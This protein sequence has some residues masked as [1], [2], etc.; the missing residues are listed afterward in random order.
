[1]DADAAVHLPAMVV[2]YSGYASAESKL[3]FLK[4][5]QQIQQQEKAR[6]IIERRKIQFEVWRPALT[7]IKALYPVES[8]PAMMGG[9]STDVITPKGGIAPENKNRVLI[10]LHG[11]GFIAGAHLFS[12]LESIPVASLGKIKVV[13]VDYRQGPEYKFPAASEDVTAVY[14]ELLKTYNP[15][16]IGIY[17]CS[18]GGDLTAEAVAWISQQNLPTPGAVGVLCGAAGGWSR[19]GDSAYIAQPLVGVAPSPTSDLGPYF[20]GV[21]VNDP[22]VQPVLSP[23]ILAKFPPTLLITST[24]DLMLSPAIYTHTQLVKAGVEAELH[25]WDGMVHAFFTVYPDIPET[26]EAL[27]VIVKFFGKHLGTD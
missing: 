16:N 8:V 4:L 24:R 14:K 26:K 2:P 22:M 15:R 5:G 13:S 10:E 27:D 12:L 21:N 20:A 18:A 1:M 11:G 6:G 25:V 9:V 19:G 3:E 23:A 7:R 17:G